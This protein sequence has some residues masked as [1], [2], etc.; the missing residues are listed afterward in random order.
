[1]KLPS[2]LYILSRYL[3]IDLAALAAL[4]LLAALAAL[5]VLA[6]FLTALVAALAALTVRAAFLTVL[7][8][9]LA[10]LAA[11]VLLMRPLTGEW[12]CGQPPDRC[13]NDVG[14]PFAALQH[15]HH[16]LQQGVW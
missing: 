4:T 14:L 11:L 15:C 10:V 1:M 2:S 5:T 3:G 13:C 12:H 8:A 7:V 16:W 6:A 9:A